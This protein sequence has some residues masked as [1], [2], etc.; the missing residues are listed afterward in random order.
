MIRASQLILLHHTARA[1]RLT[2]EAAAVAALR[3]LPRRQLLL[4]VN[5]LQSLAFNRAASSRLAVDP[6]APVVGDLIL[7][8]K[9]S[10]RGEV[11]GGGGGATAASDRDGANGGG[12][13][14]GVQGG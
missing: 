9:A 2:H 5:A 4:Y 1:H 3:R 12:L 10:Q 11:G 13:T 6:N 7:R 14:G 8:S